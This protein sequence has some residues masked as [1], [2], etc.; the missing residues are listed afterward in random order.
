[1]CAIRLSSQKGCFFLPMH[2]IYDFCQF[3]CITTALEKTKTKT[4]HIFCWCHIMGQPNCTY[5]CT[6]GRA[7]LGTNWYVLQLLILI[8]LKLWKNCRTNLLPSIVKKKNIWIN[9]CSLNVLYQKYTIGVLD[10]WS[11]WVVVEHQVSCGILYSCRPLHWCMQLSCQILVY[12]HS[13]LFWIVTTIILER[14][15]KKIFWTL[16]GWM[17]R[18]TS[19]CY[20][21]LTQ[22]NLH[23]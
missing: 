15:T 10:W 5:Q 19:S 1:M 8:C 3:V 18:I 14:K 9:K 17:K 16:L 2:I 12:W 7:I 6:S 21:V 23:G 11:L 22:C 4:K 20:L 13:T